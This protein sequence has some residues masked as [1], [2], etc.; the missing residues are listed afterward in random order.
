MEQEYARDAAANGNDD[1]LVQRAIRAIGHCEFSPVEVQ[2]AFD[3]LVRWVVDGV[4]PEGDDVLDPAVVA[5][6]LYGCRFSDAG[7]YTTGSRP[8]FAPCA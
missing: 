6:P 2:T 7:A 4:R 3:D 8:L 5:D 1:L